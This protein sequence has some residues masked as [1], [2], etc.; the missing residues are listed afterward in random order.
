MIT[1]EKFYFGF[2]EARGHITGGADGIDYNLTFVPTDGEDV[3]IR[4]TMRGRENF[5]QLLKHINDLGSG[6]IQCGETEKEP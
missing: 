3:Y 5:R 6:L 1:L 2:D 4:I